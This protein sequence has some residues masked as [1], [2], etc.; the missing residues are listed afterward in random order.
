VFFTATVT[1]DAAGAATPTGT[2]QFKVDG[3]NFGGPVTLSSS[4]AQS[5]S[6][7]ALTPGNHSVEAIYNPDPGFT[8]SNNT[9]T[10]AVNQASTTTT[11]NS[12]SPEPSTVGSSIQVFYTVAAVAPGAGTPTGGVTV[13]D[14][15]GGSCTADATTGS[16]SFIPVALFPGQ[17][18]L[19]AAY[20]GDGNFNGSTS[21]GFSHQ[22]Q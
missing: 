4:S 2:V 20:A 11:I 22:L 9:I 15:S 10:Q 6:T 7:S 18:T 13:S 14:G 21:A 12:V 19:T 16:C 5:Q 8:G 1:A 17:I 3:S